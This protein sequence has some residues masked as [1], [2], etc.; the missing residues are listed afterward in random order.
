MA[1]ITQIKPSPIYYFDREGRRNLDAVLRVVK[2]V[3][4]K[5]TE[6]QSCKIVI[7]TLEGQGPAMAYDRLRKFDPRIIAV[8]FPR[9]YRIKL[10][11][12]EEHAPDVSPNLLKFFRGVE[13]EVLVPATLPFEPIDGLEAHNQQMKLVKQTISLFGGGFTLCM[14]AV[15]HACDSGLINAG[16]DVIAFSGDTAGL[17]RA[18]TTRQFLSRFNGFAVQE[19]FCMPKKPS[20]RQDMIELLPPAP[21]EQSQRTL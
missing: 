21:K 1:N 12:G 3:L 20:A 6:L 13:I 18:S 9:T 16:E 17:F 19:I 2:R 10:P 14:E 15:L 7:F 11:N 8:T 5:R 4:N